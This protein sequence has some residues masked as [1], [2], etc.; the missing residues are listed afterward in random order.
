VKEK[1]L[2]TPIE[3][4]AIAEQMLA[5]P[6]LPEGIRIQLDRDEAVRGAFF[7]GNIAPDVQMVSGQPRDA[8][9]FFSLP[10]TNN[11]PAYV[12]MLRLH[13][14]L[15]QPARLP[16]AHA[17]FLAG[18]LAHLLLDECWV[19][20]VFYPVFGPEQTWGERQERFLL[21]NVLRAWLDRR[22]F[23]RLRDGIG[24][25]LRQAKPCHWLSFAPDSDLN[26]WRDVVADQFV[27]GAD[28]RTVA[29]FAL[30][31]RVP[32]DEFLALLEPDVIEERIFRRIPLAELDRFRDGV[33]GRTHELII[34]YFS[35]CAD[36]ERE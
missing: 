31:A 9:H 18:Y 24:D 32:D 6:A 11:Y 36:R 17:A 7:F 2:P 33:A 16:A 20:E 28:I 5:S 22:D 30:R 35:G 14:L 12:E 10:P 19:R 27:P 21:H 13:P 26:R 4:L 8:T 3:H 34:R 1:P 29:I 25:L 15:A 23:P